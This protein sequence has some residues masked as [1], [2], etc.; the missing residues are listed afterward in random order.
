MGLLLCGMAQH[1]GAACRELAARITFRFRRAVIFEV[2]VEA[3]DDGALLPV[4]PACGYLQLPR[5][6][7]VPDA[8]FHL[9]EGVVFSGSDSRVLSP[10]S[11]WL[12]A[13]MPRFTARSPQSS[14]QRRR[15][16]RLRGGGRHL[17]E[18]QAWRQSAS[19]RCLTMPDLDNLQVGMARYT[20]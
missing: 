13:K 8:H 4:E 1:C 12:S 10:L 2:E 9:Y 15:P 18:G 7:G 14:P 20:T 11:A 3:E 6:V 19:G 16:R 17:L 5:P